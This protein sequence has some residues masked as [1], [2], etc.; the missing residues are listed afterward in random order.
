VRKIPTSIVLLPGWYQANRTLS[1]Q[2]DKEKE[3]RI[4]LQ[5]LLDKGENFERATYSS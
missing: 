1:L 3:R 5:A 2:A 4:K